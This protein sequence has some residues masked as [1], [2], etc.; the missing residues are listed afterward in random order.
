MK[1]FLSLSLLFSVLC[2]FFLFLLFIQYMC[3][4]CTS[5]LYSGQQISAHCNFRKL[6]QIN[7]H[8]ANTHRA[9]KHTSML[10]THSTQPNKQMCCKWIQYFT[11]KHDII[12]KT[13]REVFPVEPKVLNAPQAC[14]SSVPVWAHIVL[15]LCHAFSPFYPNLNNHSPPIFKPSV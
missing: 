13:W 15:L 9:T 12:W 1:A 11:E 14:V 2:C 10:Q 7:K 5:A 3:V 8:T 4:S 6:T